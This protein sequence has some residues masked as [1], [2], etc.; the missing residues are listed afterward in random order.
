M[1]KIFSFF[2]V[3]W[4][5]S[6]QS[7]DPSGK[8]VQTAIEDASELIAITNYD[9]I[10]ISWKNPASSKFEKV[11]LVKSSN[12][13]PENIN[14]GEQIYIGKSEEYH[15]TKIKP[16][17]FYY[18]TIFACYENKQCS[19]GLRINSQTQSL[20]ILFFNITKNENEAQLGWEN[21]K[22]QIYQ[23]VK[24]LRKEY[25]YPENANDSESIMICEQDRLS[26]SCI[27]PNPIEADKTYYYTAFSYYI[28]HLQQKIYS[29]Y[30][31]KKI[32][33]T[34]HSFIKLLGPGEVFDTFI[35]ADKN[36]YVVASGFTNLNP[37]E[38]K[39]TV[40]FKTNNFEQTQ[41]LE[42]F[43]DD[44][45][46]N[47]TIFFNQ[48]SNSELHSF[49]EDYL[50]MLDATYFI[51]TNL[52]TGES[53]AKK[54]EVN[55]YK[56][57]PHTQ[58]EKTGADEYTL[59]STA[60]PNFAWL[61]KVN[62]EGNITWGKIY[63]FNTDITKPPVFN[64]CYSFV[65]EIDNYILAGNEV[66]HILDESGAPTD[67]IMYPWILKT[68]LNGEPL[69]QKKLIDYPGDGI[70]HISKNNNNIYNLI[71]YSVIENGTLNQKNLT[72]LKIDQSGNI[73]SKKIITQIPLMLKKIIKT[74]NK[75]LYILF[76]KQYSNSC[77]MKLTVNGDI[78]W[79]KC[80]DGNSGFPEAELASFS[81]TPDES[82]ILSGKVKVSGNE[83]QAAIIKMTPNGNINF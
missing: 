52:S 30:P 44:Y 27:D 80:A 37:G 61:G 4:L 69:W 12:S 17:N 62:F 50:W 54:L 24:I 9:S 75:N 11:L 66:N 43:P 71:I 78:L 10:S 70:Y 73:L 46:Y 21:P 42:A 51:K 13:Y 28:N 83:C 33:Y 82:I 64:S 25:S 68:D 1:K 36:F 72:L 20:K 14:N 65:K 2:L 79:S 57:G 26:T 76:D 48:I 6:C 63:D 32:L 7:A 47:K 55:T 19:S 8:I 23:G 31:E 5:L 74:Q 18:Y 34:G 60:Y 16:G 15:D 59:C 49:Y 29:E 67:S 45:F 38:K 39:G 41:W 40:R 22:N 35:L 56:I 53:V 81:I 58:V 77:L 3:F